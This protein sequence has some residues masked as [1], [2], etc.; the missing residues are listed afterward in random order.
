MNLAEIYKRKDFVISFEVF[1]PKTL[2]SEKNLYDTINQLL[3]FGPDFISCT[4]GALGKNNKGTIDICAKIQKEFG[5]TTMAHLTCLSY[6]RG[7]LLHEV[8]R[9]QKKGIFNIMALRGDKNEDD[10]R[11]DGLHYANE[12]VRLLRRYFPRL[13]IGVAG[14]PEKHP[15]APNE[16]SDLENLK[17]KV[18]E[19]ADVVFTQLFYVNEYFFKFRDKYVSSGIKAPLIPGIMPITDYNNVKRI[20]SLCK[21]T[22]PKELDEKILSVK[23]DK[24][25]VLSIGVEFAVKQCEE[26]IANGVQGLHFFILN[27]WKPCV[28]ILSKLGLKEKKPLIA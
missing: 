24:N 27:Q 9:A 2:E 7:D 17:R 21:S 14:Y 6:E 12:F 23:D 25:A 8:R 19:G 18:D 15:E 5:I 22:F 20:T 1:P 28:S 13:G 11:K 4:H 16:K 26:L 3:V 10:V